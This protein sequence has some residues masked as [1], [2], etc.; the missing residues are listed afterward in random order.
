MPQRGPQHKDTR[1][2]ARVLAINIIRE[3]SPTHAGI[4]HHS[5]GNYAWRQRTRAQ[6]LMTAVLLSS[7]NRIIPHSFG[8]NRPIVINTEPLLKKV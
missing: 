3:Y 2:L 5:A 7:D 1:K 8:R 4:D 6:S